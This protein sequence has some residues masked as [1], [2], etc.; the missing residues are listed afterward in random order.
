M[1]ALSS[2]GPAQNFGKRK[3]SL[4]GVVSKVLDSHYP[5]GRGR[6]WVKKTCAQRETQTIAGLALDGNEW[7]GIYLTLDAA[8]A[9][10]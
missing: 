7:D 4:E 1:A 2:G 5:S 9:M 6:D 8:R 3:V 10:T